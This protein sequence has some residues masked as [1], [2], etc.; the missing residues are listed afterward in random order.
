MRALYGAD[1]EIVATFYDSDLPKVPAS[2]TTSVAIS[3]LDVDEVT[4]NLPSIARVIS[5]VG[6]TNADG[7]QQFYVSAGQIIERDPWTEVYRDA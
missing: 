1:G 5:S 6:R 3:A 4:A 2:F 7:M